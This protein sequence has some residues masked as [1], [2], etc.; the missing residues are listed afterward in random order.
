MFRI[1]TIPLRLWACTGTFDNL[2][3][4]HGRTDIW[5]TFNLASASMPILC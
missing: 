1:V 5:V 2:V 4:L 3:Q